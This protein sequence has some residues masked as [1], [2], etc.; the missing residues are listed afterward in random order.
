MDGVSEYVKDLVSVIVPCRNEEKHIGNLLQAILKQTFPAEHLEVIIA[1]GM[2]EDRT[3]AKIEAFKARHPNLA[4]RVVDNPE[5]VI[6]TALNHAIDAARGEYILRLDAH[7]VPEP[8]YLANSIADVKAGKGDN[9]GGYWVIQPGAD[10]WIARSI[11]CAGGNKLGVGATRYRTSGEAGYVET[12]PFGAFRHDLI[13]RIGKYDPTLLSN[14]DYE[15]N[16]RILQNGGKVYFNPAIRIAYIARSTLDELARQYWRYG[17]WKQRMLKK[18]PESL[19]L[20]QAMPP[21]FVGAV[22]LGGLL[23]PFLPG[24][25]PFYGAGLLLYLIVVILSGIP[26]ALEGKDLRLILGI[27]LAIITMHVS[28]GTGFIWSW[29]ESTFNQKKNEKR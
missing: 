11:A 7:S 21:L 4:L 3:R 19:Q 10:S 14:E 8:D 29:F 27:P 18:S 17:Y 6:P 15:L 28:W 2:S 9:V 24:V 12:V 25:R 5:Q 26:Q 22:A 23:S 20:R 16:H 13:D 1:D